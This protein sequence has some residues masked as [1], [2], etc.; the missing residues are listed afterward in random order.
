[1]TLRLPW[2][3]LPAPPDPSTL[4][5]SLVMLASEGRAFSD[6]AVRVAAEI[7]RPARASV[8]VLSIARIWGSAFGLPHPG[9]RPTKQ[10]WQSQRDVVEAAINALKKRGLDATGEVYGSRNAAKSILKLADA[11]GAGALVMP[12]DPEPH[13][14]VRGILWAHLP[15]VVAR[16]S[17]IPVYLVT[18]H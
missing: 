17:S 1:M 2:H 12:A 6:G 9:L 3:T 7:A 14:A 13:W 11:A 15:Y 5:P 4:R 16:A 10:E 18:D 8:K